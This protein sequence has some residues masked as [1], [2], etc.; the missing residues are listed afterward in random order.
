MKIDRE[1]LKGAAATL[2]LTLLDQSPAHGYE[3]AQRIRSRTEGLCTLGEGT[4]YPLLYSL[5]NKGWIKGTW[6][7]APSGRRRRV[8]TV[9][10]R[11]RKQLALRKEQWNTLVTGMALAMGGV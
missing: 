9:T 11:G 2:V 3:L 8:Y 7:T 1:L 5:A 6:Q 4:L 10:Q